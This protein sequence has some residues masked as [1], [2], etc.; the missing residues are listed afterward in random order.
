MDQWFGYMGEILRAD[1]SERKVTKEPL[2]KDVAKSYIGCTGYAVRTLW[3]ELKPGVNPLAPENEIIFSTGPLTGTLCPGSG[4][5]EVCFKSPLTGIWGEARSGGTFGPKMKFSGFDFILLKGKS[6]EPVY[7]WVCDGEAEIRDAKHIWGKTVNETTDIILKEIGSPK[8]SVACIGPAGENLVKFASVVNDYY[9]V[10]AR[11]A[12]GT[13]MGSKNVKAVAVYGTKDIAIA[14]PERF[15][16]TITNAQNIVLKN[17][18][19]EFWRELGTPGILDI[20]NSIG[21]LPTKHGYTCYFENAEKTSGGKLNSEYVVRREACFG[22]PFGCGRITEVKSGPYSVPPMGGPEYE[23]MCMLGSFCF[24]DNLEALIKANYLCNNYGLDTI[25]TGNIIAFTMECYEKGWLTDADMGDVKPMWGDSEAILVLIEKIAKREGIGNL[26][27]DGV[28]NA[29]IK[30]GKGAPELA[31]QVKGLEVPGKD[32]RGEAKTMALQFALAPRGACH[33]HPNSPSIW[34][35]NKLDNGLKPFG[36]PWPPADEFEETGVGKGLAYKLMALHGTICEIMGTCIFYVWGSEGDCLTPK[37]YA[38]IFSDLT[39]W[40]I[41]QFELMKIA[42]R[43]WNLKRCFN[44]REGVSRKD[45]TLPK[46]FMEPVVSGPTKGQAVVNLNGMLDEY[47]EAS[48]WNV[49]TGV[50]TKEKLEEMELKDVA[51]ELAKLGKL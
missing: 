49:K 48:G 51:E 22:C 47:Y 38:E 28:K 17:S 40:R 50:P 10:A 39:G 16:E 25:S 21:R 30:I 9:R 3:E 43:V 8:A 37:N 4:S 34:D 2:R 45:D 24:H 36:L 27:A 5:Y 33:M 12:P 14:D 23:T 26:L 18:L 41:D 46:R 20:N 6:E 15:T 35:S 1:L 13:V 32:P 44:V 29:A 31:M 11:C 7:L 42:E 19:R